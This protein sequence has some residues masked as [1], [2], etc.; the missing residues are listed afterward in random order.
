MA[1]SIDDLVAAVK[2]TNAA[3]AAPDRTQARLEAAA[4]H[5]QA[6]VSAY[7]QESRG[8]AGRGGGGLMA[9]ECD[10]ASCDLIREAYGSVEAWREGEKESAVADLEPEWL[11]AG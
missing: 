8:G 11:E 9:A 10:C 3:L 1:T 6:T 5:E 2:A 7:L 4:K